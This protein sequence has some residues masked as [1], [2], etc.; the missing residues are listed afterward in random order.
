MDF[1][2]IQ[3]SIKKLILCYA[4]Y[5]AEMPFFGGFSRTV[6]V[7]VTFLSRKG[8]VRPK[9]LIEDVKIR[10]V[11]TVATVEKNNFNNFFVKRI[12]NRQILTLTEALNGKTHFFSCLNSEVSI[13]P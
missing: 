3:F 2:I 8:N 12:L 5:I 1:R 6:D 10:T 13:L 11:W 7:D 4:K 9:S